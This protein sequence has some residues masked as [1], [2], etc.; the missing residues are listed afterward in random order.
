MSDGVNIKTREIVS[1]VV[2]IILSAVLIISFNCASTQTKLQQCLSM[3]KNKGL[4]NDKG[5]DSAFI[6]K[7]RPFHREQLID[8]YTM[9]Q[10]PKM[11]W[12]PGKNGK[13]GKAVID[14]KDGKIQW[15]PGVP[16]QKKALFLF[17]EKGVTD[18]IE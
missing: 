11:K 3:S 17:V 14:K 12:Q 15:V 2:I 9:I 4:I 8:K 6:D 5:K 7:C 16:M 13:N 18:G 10:T 1:Y